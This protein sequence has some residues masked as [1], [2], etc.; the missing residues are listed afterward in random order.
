MINFTF[1]IED[2]IIFPPE[3]FD[4]RKSPNKII[5]NCIVLSKGTIILNMV[6]SVEMQ[7]SGYK[8]WISYVQMFKRVRIFLPRHC[9]FHFLYYRRF[10]SP[11]FN[12]TI[13]V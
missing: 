12:A 1:E 2:T 4:T 6:T 11:N 7:I 10:K 13:K 3:S 8:L 9:F 5:S